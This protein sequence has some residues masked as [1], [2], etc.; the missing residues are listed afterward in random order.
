MDHYG[1]S[2]DE[3]LTILS[4]NAGLLGLSGVSNDLRLV[5]EAADAGNSQA[6]LAVD[7]LC[8]NILGYIGM[9]AAY[10][11]GLDALVF[12]GG[13]GTNSDVLRKKVC[14]NLGYLGLELD[15]EKNAGRGDGKISTDSSKVSVWRLKTDEESVVAACVREFLKAQ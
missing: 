15:Q 7:T 9:Y 14:E 13:I 4:K 8:D 10:L 2:L 12:T 11:N 3:T 1:Y 6:Q 5:M